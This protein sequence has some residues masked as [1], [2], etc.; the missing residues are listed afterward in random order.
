MKVYRDIK[1][2]IPVP[3]AIVTV[4][5]FDGVHLGHQAILKRMVNEA[6][7]SGGETVV[8]TFYPHPRQVL[9][10]DSSNLRFISTQEKKIERLKEIGIDNLIII[11]FTKDFSRIPSET[12]IK[13]YII[14]I[15]HPVKLVVGY[16]HHFGK[17]RMGDYKQLFDL[18]I[19]YHFKVERVPAQDVEHIAVS[20]TKIRN[21]LN[22]GDVV[23]A[24]SLL[25]YQYTIYG[26]V[27]HGNKLGRTWGFPTAN[28]EF[29]P[30][31]K[32]IT[33]RG[34]YACFVDYNGKSYQGMTNIGKR[35]T[36]TDEGE[37]TIEVNIFDFDED[38][39]DK[40]ISIRFV[41]RLRDEKKFDSTDHLKKQLEM[42]K[43]KAKEVLSKHLSIS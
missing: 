5:T 1:K 29:P 34:V 11:E 31:Y 10:L 30:E 33:T 27:C 37:L 18:G 21:A 43:T 4:G 17:N 28:L 2:F 6:K 9:N 32:L 13:D 42:D 36:I 15:I 35:P 40:T 8:I 12:F 7:A 23:R 3:K 16:D 22:L 39:Y 41:E 25:G 20:S 26:K 14:K 38:I 24:N 19:E